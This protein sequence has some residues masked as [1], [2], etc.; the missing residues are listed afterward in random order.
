M[1]KPL[2]AKRLFAVVASLAAMGALTLVLMDNL[3]MPWYTQHGEGVTVPDV[4]NVS[5]DE[6]QARIEAVGLRSD[7]Y[8][9]RPNEVLPPGH[10]MDQTPSGGTVVKPNRKI[11][12]MI[13]AETRP[14]VGMP[15]LI[16][17]SL[18][19]AR[20]QL[21][22]RG[23]QLGTIAYES[24][25]YR[26]SVL[27]QSVAPG[28]D[29]RRNARVDLVIGDGVGQRRVAMPTLTGLR[30]PAAQLRIREA[31]LYVGDITYE[32]SRLY[33]AGIVIRTN[34]ATSDSLFEGTSIHL[35]V[36][37]DPNVQEVI[38]AG[39]ATDSIPTPRMP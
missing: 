25:P 13:S 19:N 6:A 18:D 36:T 37:E 32:A 33:P 8:D 35:T 15:S 30:L 26:N 24:S 28:S 23:L 9:Q 7:V 17:N 14:T 3:V 10:V 27:S 22:V 20:I 34:P 12:L 11:Y 16:G 38:E 31:G 29:I 21:Q 2:F 1:T 39:V 5:L 4:K